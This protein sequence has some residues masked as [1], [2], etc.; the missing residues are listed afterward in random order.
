MPATLFLP[1]L[2]APPDVPQ[3]RQCRAHAGQAALA[4]PCSPPAPGP[5]VPPG[6]PPSGDVVGSQSAPDGSIAALR[7]ESA[8]SPST[9]P[10]AQSPRLPSGASQDRLATDGAGA[11]RA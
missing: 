10:G 4:M 2:T 1:A 9:L 11:V 3:G 7:Y 8:P 5:T 6:E